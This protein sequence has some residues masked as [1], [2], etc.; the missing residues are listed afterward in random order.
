MGPTQVDI[1]TRVKF[2]A[3]VGVLV[4]VVKRVGDDFLDDGLERRGRAA[5]VSGR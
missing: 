4:G 2:D 3:V 5:V 1:P